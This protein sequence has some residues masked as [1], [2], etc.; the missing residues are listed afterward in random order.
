MSKHKHTPGP[1]RAHFYD[2]GSDTFDIVQ[3]DDDGYG[4]ALIEAAGMVCADDHENQANARLIAAAPQLLEAC[5]ALLADAE[6][7]KGAYLWTGSEVSTI[8]SAVM[9]AEEGEG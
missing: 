7:R 2:D 1:W 5:K 9:A 8:R 6:V 3:F 4:P